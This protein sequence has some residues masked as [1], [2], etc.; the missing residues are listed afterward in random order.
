MSVSSDGRLKNAPT[1]EIRQRIIDGRINHLQKE[2]DGF[3]KQ[4]DNLRRLG[5][6]C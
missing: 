2:I 1:P 3:N 6:M 4:V 5:G